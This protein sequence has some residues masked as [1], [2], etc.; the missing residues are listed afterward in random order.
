[1]RS[2]TPWFITLCIVLMSL[3]TG[4]ST[5]EAADE[6]DTLIFGV[7]DD[8]VTLDPAVTVEGG[9]I[10]I[11]MQLYERLVAFDENDFTQFVPEIAESWE[12][13]DDGKRWTF[14][15]RDNGIFAGG[16]PITADDVVFSLQRVLNLGGNASGLLAQFSITS[17]SITRVDDLTVQ[18]ELGKPYA[19]GPF[20]SVLASFPGSILDQQAVQAHEQ[21]QDQ[22]KAWL[23]DHSAGSGRFTIAERQAGERTVLTVNP[24][25]RQQVAPIRQ[26]IVQNVPDPFEQGLLLEKGEIDV[27]WNLQASQ[28][29]RLEQNPDVQIF[30]TPTLTIGFVAMNLTY[31][32]FQKADVRNA[33]RYALDYDSIVN[34]IME[35][36]V[37][38]TQTII[39]KGLV[40]YNPDMPYTYDIDRAKQLLADAGY[41]GGFDLELACLNYAPWIDLAAQI[42]SDLAQIGIRVTI[43]EM[44]VSDMVQQVAISRD[45]QMFVW[46]FGLDY[47]DTD[48][49]AKTFAHC[50]SEGEDATVKYAA[51]VARY[52]QPDLTALTEQA[53]REQDP[54]K[55]EA[56]YRQITETV[57]DDGPYAVLYIPQQ[58]YGVRFEIRD[59]IGFPPFITSRFPFLN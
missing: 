19:A 28:I 1:M 51:W 2:S 53:A 13:L 27:A 18:I 3:G 57:L 50:D 45:F 6:K 47:P 36:T 20:F 25:Y 29:R 21:N 17:S 38:K 11:I 40:G 5:I 26:V 37:L 48:A 41:P 35:G 55:R 22:G 44:P 54:A 15:L 59:W 39:P 12:S 49:A 43:T 10:G 14:Y 24:K 33:I 4:L 34:F 52:C 30:E 46:Q 42:K 9:S 31:E 8:S 58:V 7:Q 23:A 32:P 16:N 56:E